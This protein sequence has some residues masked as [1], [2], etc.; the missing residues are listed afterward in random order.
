MLVSNK[1]SLRFTMIGFSVPFLFAN[2]RY[3]CVYKLL[4]TVYFICKFYHI[5]AP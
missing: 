4:K 2:D 3:I 1:I 5:S